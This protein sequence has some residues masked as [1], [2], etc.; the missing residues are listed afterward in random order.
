MGNAYCPDVAYPF[1]RGNV[2]PGRPT[3]ARIETTNLFLLTVLPHLSVITA[4]LSISLNDT[5]F[6]RGVS[7]RTEM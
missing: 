2:P 6:G 5:Y 4:N 1:M 7:F 3:P